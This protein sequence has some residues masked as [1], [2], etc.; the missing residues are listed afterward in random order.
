M[1]PINRR[2]VIAG[3]AALGAATA[4]GGFGVT[5]A[6]EASPAAVPVGGGGDW[7]LYGHDVTGAKSTTTAG[8]SATDVA[9]L[10]PLW[11]VE[12]G[13]PVSS[14]PVIAGG[15]AYVGSYDGNLYA[16][17]LLTGGLV[18]TYATGAA[19]PEPNLQIPLGI[20]GSAAVD[21]DAVYVGDATATLHALDRSTGLAFWSRKL[22][23]QPNASIWSSPVVSEGVIYI[24]VASIAKEV[25][26]RGSVVAVDQASGAPLWQTYMVPEGADGAGVFAVPAIDVER[27]LLYVGT[28]NAYS[29]TPAPY[30][31]S[32]SVVALD[33]ATG[34]LRWAFASPEHDGETA[35]VDDVG[36]SASPN[37]FTADVDGT[38]RDIVG[39]GQKSG[40]YWALDRE[41]G[42]EI[43]RAQV[44]PA[45]FLGGMEGTS[46]YA[47]GI[48]VVP[49][50]DWPEF[51]GPATGLVTGLDASTGETVWT[52]EQ[53]APAASPAAISDDVAFQAG[54]DGILHAYALADGTE[55]WSA[56]LGASVSGGVAVADGTVVVGAATPQ[57]APFILPGSSIRAFGPPSGAAT[58]VGSPEATPVTSPDAAPQATP[59]A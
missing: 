6:Q 17:D 59:V 7:P 24:G 37:L 4:L 55:L 3:S 27:G 35:P 33:I 5:G 44:S 15:V 30:G 45:G 23:E 34:E 29:E 22:D 18:W 50:T 10:S 19:V 32:L 2:Q 13:G 46:A 57:F 41:T 31:N 49:A 26:F 56:D 58:P 20:T 21:A 52:V 38:P 40:V 16:I 51:E 43:W 36:F 48:V 25:G 28:Q 39:V 54:F 42:E 14:T 47:D 9:A 53:T 1:H 11:E 8:I 12:V